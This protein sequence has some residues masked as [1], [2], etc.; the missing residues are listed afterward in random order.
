MEFS[1]L[2]TP[3]RRRKIGNLSLLKFLGE[4]TNFRFG[5]S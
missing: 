1:E 2:M 4:A 5:W 3:H